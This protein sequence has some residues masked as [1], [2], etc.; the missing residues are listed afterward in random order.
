MKIALASPTFPA[1]IAD[2]LA[3]IEQLSKKAALQEA[4]I[5]CFPDIDPGKATGLLA[6]RFKNELFF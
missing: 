1:S 6:K 2:G 4:A 3:S 5:I